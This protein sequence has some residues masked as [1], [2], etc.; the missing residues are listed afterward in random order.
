[1]RYVSSGSRPVSSVNTR[2]SGE[3]RARHVHDHHALGLKRSRDGQRTAELGDSPFQQ[4]LA[5][6]LLQTLDLSRLRK[7]AQAASAL[8]TRMIE[9]GVSPILIVSTQS[10]SPCL[11]NPSGIARARCPD[12]QHGGM[13]RS[14]GLAAHGHERVEIRRGVGILVIGGRR[15]HHKIALR[16]SALMVA[17]HRYQAVA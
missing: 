16:R 4:S 11:A 5:R 12:A 13:R 10:F 15:Q 2:T 8:P 6:C 7:S 14:G 1:M 3:I 17:V 9:T